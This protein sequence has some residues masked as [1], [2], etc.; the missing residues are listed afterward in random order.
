MKLR[1]SVMKQIHAHW[2]VELYNHMTTGEGKKNIMSEW[3]AAGILDTVNL[4]LRNLPTV[5]PFSDIDPMLDNPRS[6]GQH[7]D[8]L[9]DM[10]EGEIA[11]G[12]S[13]AENENESDSDGN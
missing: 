10:S 4:G 11:P 12:Y 3:R 2:M 6:D 5:D 9:C 7:L 8:E 13:R 1:L